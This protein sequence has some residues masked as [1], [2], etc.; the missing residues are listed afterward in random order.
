ME[1]VQARIR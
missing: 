1:R